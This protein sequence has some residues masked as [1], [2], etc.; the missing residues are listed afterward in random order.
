[1]GK[2][3]LFIDNRERSGLE[4]LVK[5]YCDSKH[6]P[7]QTRQNMITD[8]AFGSVGIESKS[9]ADYMGSLYS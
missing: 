6:L 8:Y 7:Y 1:M 4:D 5:K 3:I 9:M 2:K